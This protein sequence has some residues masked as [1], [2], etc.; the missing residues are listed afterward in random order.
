MHPV[1]KALWFVE[2]NSKSD[3]SLDDVA[4]SCGLSRFALTRAFGPATGQSVMGYVRGRRLTE[5]ARALA[6]GAGDILAVALDSGYGSHEAFTRAFRDHFGLT[7]EAVRAQGRLDGL[8]IIE[9][10]RKEIMTQVELEPPQMRQHKTLLIA[11]FC[12]RY[13]NET[14]AQIPAQWQRFAPHIGSVPGQV[15]F[16]TYGV[17]FNTDDA[18]VCDYICG[19]EVSGFGLVPKDWATL[20]IQER[21]YA[22]FHHRDHIA[23]IHQTFQAIWGQWAPSSGMV[24]D[25]EPSFEVYRKA[26]NPMTGMG[27]VEIWV[28]VRG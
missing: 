27:G 7:P 25:G 1:E 11:G 20:R 5:A 10:I 19:V 18:G 13:T 6:A 28:P 24:A 17:I 15:G 16:A 14:R 2:S 8:K 4:S 22:V 21:Q 12:E 26:F 3:L 23:S 9:P